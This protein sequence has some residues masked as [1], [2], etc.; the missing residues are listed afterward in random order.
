MKNLLLTFLFSGLFSLGAFAQG[1]DPC[2]ACTILPSGS[3]YIVFGDGIYTCTGADF[4]GEC[5]LLVSL[6]IELV[7]FDATLVDNDVKLDWVTATEENN[8]GFEIQRSFDGRNFETI[9]FVA[10]SG[11]TQETKNYDFSDKNIQNRALSNIIY[12][13]LKQ[14]DYD[15]TEV[16]TEAISIKMAAEAHLD[17]I[18]VSN[19]G[20]SRGDNETA[21]YFNSPTHTDINVSVFDI[22]G[23]L[24]IQ[25]V[26]D[27]DKGINE[28]KLE[29]ANLQ[30]GLY[31]ISMDNGFSVTTTKYLR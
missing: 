20:G 11:T 24:M 5:N 31:I 13:R 7:T 3:I 23:K 25:T 26:I 15:G 2:L 8:A 10:G 21:I 12:Y 17:I 27:A 6:P 18:S 30:S 9:D 14:M 1:S 29:V 28:A 4:S 22:N 16:Y 19:N